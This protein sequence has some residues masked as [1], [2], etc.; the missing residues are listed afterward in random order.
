[1]Y[2]RPLRTK[3]IGIYSTV[4]MEQDTLSVEPRT[5]L[6]CNIPTRDWTWATRQ[7]LAH[8]KSES[9]LQYSETLVWYR[10]ENRMVDYKRYLKPRMLRLKKGTYRIIADLVYS[11]LGTI[12]RPFSSTFLSRSKVDRTDAAASVRVDWAICF[13]GQIL[14]ERWWY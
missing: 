1:M 8:R 6:A 13:P 4:Y 7:T 5:I 10:K 12:S 14:L 11:F 2:C 3:E 9:A